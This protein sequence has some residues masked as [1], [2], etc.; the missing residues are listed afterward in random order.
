MPVPGHGH[1]VYMPPGRY[2]SD[3]D[4]PNVHKG[5][6]RN[7]TLM[8]C[9]AQCLTLLANQTV[10][11]SHRCTALNYDGGT[12]C[13]VVRHCAAGA[14]PSAVDK[15]KEDIVALAYEAGPGPQGDTST[16]TDTGSA[17]VHLRAED[18]DKV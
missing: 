11:A 17:G 6:Y 8:A 7:V 18:R 15:G 10:P 5:N 9:Q 14:T 3:K 12:S 2:F 1:W 13:C 16:D 4:C